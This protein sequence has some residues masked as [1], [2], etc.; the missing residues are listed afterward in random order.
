MIAIKD[1]V[2]YLKKH[3]FNSLMLKN[4]FKIFILILVAIMFTFT[5]SYTFINKKADNDMRINN[6]VSLE[7]VLNLMEDTIHQSEMIVANVT[8]DNEVEMFMNF[9]LE[10]IYLDNQ[11][12]M[13]SIKNK[14]F[15]YK[16]TIRNIHSIYVYSKKNGRV[17]TTEG[18]YPVENFEDN[19]WEKIEPSELI[20]VLPRKFKDK[21][22]HFITLIKW[23]KG[24]GSVVINV[25]ISEVK[26]FIE[27]NIESENRLYIADDRGKIIYSKNQYDFLKQVDELGKRDGIEISN[28]EFVSS[29]DYWI[30]KEHSELYE[31]EYYLITD[32][33]I[34]SSKYNID[35]LRGMFIFVALFLLIV[36]LIVSLAVS[37]MTFIPIANI[38]RILEFDSNINIDQLKSNETKYIAQ[39]MFD[40]LNENAELKNEM[41]EK[42]KRS[43]KYEAIALQA[44]INPHFINN[45]LSGICYT[46]MSKY[47]YDKTVMDQFQTL[48]KFVRYS[49]NSKKIFVPIREELNFLYS[50]VNLMSLKYGEIS[51]VYNIPEEM[52]QREIVRM[53]L[54]PIVENSIF[55]GLSVKQE[56][57]SIKLEVDGDDEYTVIS[58]YDNGI[59]ITDDKIKQIMNDKEA[60]EFDTKGGMGL[61][62]VIKRLKILC[63]KEFKFSIESE[64]GE[65]TKITFYFPHRVDYD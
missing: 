1:T 36:A 60:S 33:N 51:F 56:K 41:N 18:I 16:S 39:K 11:S 50:Y 17:I 40:I 26:T 52:E 15:M 35:F 31:W 44:Q 20:I 46:I 62:N 65:F 8:K 38:M 48:I 58:I 29:A 28:G 30:G 57:K 3:G 37:I 23:V 5:L 59:G 42:L 34:Y 21:Y 53:S 6:S 64:I 7:R 63:G 32:K 27:N 49:S 9:S 24:F 13:N 45:T 2:L 14:L 19:V 4:F 55:H 43:D 12:L 61:K 54:Q 25:D 22:P 47:N 10:E